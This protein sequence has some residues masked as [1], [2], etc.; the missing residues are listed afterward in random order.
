MRE[1]VNE[2]SEGIGDGLG[3]EVVGHGREVGPGGVTAQD[4][5]DAGAEHESGDKEP[6]GPAD[7][8]GRGIRSGP[9]GKDSGFFKEDEEKTSFKEKGIPLEREEVLTDVDEGQPAKP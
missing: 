5:D 6:E 8:V 2:P 4:F 3:F 9:S 7:K 1:L